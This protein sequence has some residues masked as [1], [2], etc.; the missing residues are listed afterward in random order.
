MILRPA[1]KLARRIKLSGGD[2]HFAFRNLIVR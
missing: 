1:Q 2:R